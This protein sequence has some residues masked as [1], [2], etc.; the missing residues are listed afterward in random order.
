MKMRFDKSK[1]DVNLNE[2]GEPIK[3]T[4]VGAKNSYFEHQQ[5]LAD[6]ADELAI[7]L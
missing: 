4:F 2:E 3:R 1:A 7:T 6:Q 5:I